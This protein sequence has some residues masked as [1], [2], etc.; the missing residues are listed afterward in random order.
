MDAAQALADLAAV[1]SQIE[2]AVLTGADGALVA[3]TFPDEERGRRVADAALA[4]VAA[5]EAS[6]AVGERADLTQ[7]L[8]EVRDGAV[9][10][11]RE[12]ERVVAA[13]T[14]AE[15]TV[16]LVFYDLKTSLRLADE[17]EPPKRAARARQEPPAKG[18]TSTGPRKRSPKKEGDA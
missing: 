5:A 12:G 10:A 8:A 16:G 1:S 18:T 2:G 17:A 3:S 13:V 7:V 11:V 4:L 6:D 15:P 14:G 9:F